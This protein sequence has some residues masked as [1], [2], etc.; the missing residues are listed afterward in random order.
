VRV[1]FCFF[2]FIFPFFFFFFFSYHCNL[3]FTYFVGCCLPA[4]NCFVLIVETFVIE[5]GLVPLFSG[6]PYVDYDSASSA[7]ASFW[8]LLVPS[9]DLDKF[10]LICPS[11]ASVTIFYGSLRGSNYLFNL[12]FF[13]FVIIYALF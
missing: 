12:F 9:G 3:L 6:V 7:S 1:F 5:F 8:W 4:F 10:A 13:E 2:F 11:F